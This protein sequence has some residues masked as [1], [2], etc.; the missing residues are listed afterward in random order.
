[1]SSTFNGDA[2]RP[3]LVRVSP[4]CLP[5]TGMV[6]SIPRV[7]AHQT[8][9]CTH[10]VL[11]GFPWPASGNCPLHRS[12]CTPLHSVYIVLLL[13]ISIP[14]H[15]FLL[16]TSPITSTPTGLSVTE[17]VSHSRL[18]ILISIL[19]SSC[20]DQTSWATSPHSYN[21]QLLTHVVKY[22]EHCAWM[23]GQ[24]I[25]TNRWEYWFFRWYYLHTDTEGN[26]LS[27]SSAACNKYDIN[28]NFITMLNI[29]SFFQKICIGT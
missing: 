8:R 29:F 1:M 15:L 21:R 13:Y 2:S 10:A 28:L 22:V 23:G 9:I 18:T 27:C 16:F 19:S 3:Y 14:P 17:W 5:R 24:V 25:A 20:H 26:S 7:A 11:L 6:T 12:L 4:S